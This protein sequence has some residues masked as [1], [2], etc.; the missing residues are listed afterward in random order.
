MSSVVMTELDAIIERLDQLA[1][2]RIPT[3]LALWNYEDIAEYL[4]R[5]RN[6]VMNRIAV[7]PD[8]PRAIRIKGGHPLYEAREVI[9][10]AKKHKGRNAA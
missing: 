2:R 3:E 1:R 8:F 10:W 6:T 9:A 4:R 5:S 7:L